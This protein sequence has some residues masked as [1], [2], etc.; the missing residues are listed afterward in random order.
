MHL[1]LTRSTLPHNFN[2]VA[3]AMQRLYTSTFVSLPRVVHLCGIRIAALRLSARLSTKCRHHHFSTTARFA[4]TRISDVYDIPVGSNGYFSLR[5]THPSLA[6][7]ATGN[8]IIHLPSGPLFQSSGDETSAAEPNG[9]GNAISDSATA[10][11]SLADATAS[12]IV[13][14]NYRLGL[15]PYTES[16]VP[17]HLRL[18]DTEP[19]PQHLIYQFPTPVHDTLTGF[20][21][22]LE[23]LNPARI[24]VIGTHIGGS[25][26][27]MLALTEP[28]T[29]NAVA[30]IEPVCD[31]SSLDEFCTSPN[32][33]YL[34]R[35]RTNFP[36]DLVPLL[37]ARERFFSAAEKYFDSFASPILF[38]RS[39]GKYVP[40]VFPRYRTGPGYPVPVLSSEKSKSDSESEALELW[41]TFIPDELV[42]GEIGMGDFPE[43]EL[44]AGSNSIANGD[45]DGDGDGESPRV[46][47]R[48][49]LSR[50]PPYGLDY[51]SS[52]PRER[53][54]REP[55]E[56][57]EV[58][59]PWVRI[60]TPRSS[61]QGT[62]TTTPAEAGLEGIASEAETAEQPDT[63]GTRR[64]R[65]MHQPATVLAHQAAEMVDVM[66]RA[67]FFGRE[68]GVAE[69][70]V[71]L[72]YSSPASGPGAGLVSVSEAADWDV[73]E[74]ERSPEE[75]AKVETDLV[76]AVKWLVQTLNSAPK[77]EPEE[78]GDAGNR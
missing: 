39:A 40:K 69:G 63:F 48:K 24:G 19:R 72:A 49:A 6:P 8:V 75:V 46:R 53:Y 11:Q 42:Q 38:L 9:D 60:F 44:H 14:I 21:W 15:L 27:L 56:K 76:G 13:T 17:Q 22:V 32:S 34:R 77:Q 10:T 7:Q 25:L 50:W 45:G 35:K 36:K 16:Q 4:S 23:N 1:R 18:P 20:D 2:H 47:R 65:K 55:V 70:R 74:S 64:K 62:T 41:D 51:G 58:E 59:L 28:R 57:L 68:R 12:S 78:T 30:A 54:S 73:T 31:W 37:Q 29:V 71:T 5:V 67:C 61:V 66:R 52:G 43:S 3:L 33:P 26:A